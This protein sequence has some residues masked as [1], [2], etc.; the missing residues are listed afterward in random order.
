M[1]V[2]T[3]KST[4]RMKSTP[5]KKRT[6]TMHVYLT[7]STFRMTTKTSF[8]TSTAA[9]R[10]TVS[11]FVPTSLTYTRNTENSPLVTTRRISTPKNS[12][13]GELPRNNHSKDNKTV[14]VK[15]TTICMILLLV[16]IVLGVFFWVKRKR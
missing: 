6:P 12:S 4:L 7:K 11:K 8:N 5:A 14:S 16:I 3:T 9:S 2:F 15:A 1:P 10:A 13:I